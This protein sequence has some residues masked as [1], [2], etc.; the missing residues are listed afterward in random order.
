VLIQTEP[1]GASLIMDGAIVGR[2][3]AQFPRPESGQRQ[4]ELRL[5]GY[6]RQV[7]RIGAD[8]GDQV[9]VTL[10]R[11]VKAPVKKP[12]AAATKKPEPKIDKPTRKSEVV[13]P[14]AN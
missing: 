12:V 7:V 5:E 10:R 1:S 3:P 14:W 9:H 11:E 13:D 2:T 4:L 6:Q 8:S